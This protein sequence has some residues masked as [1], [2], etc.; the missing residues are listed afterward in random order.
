M[1]IAVALLTLAAGSVIQGIYE[2]PGG[3]FFIAIVV[4]VLILVG[5]LL[6]W[7][8]YDDVL[9]VVLVILGWIFLA[10]VAGLFLM[11]E[12]ILGFAGLVV[13]FL[14]MEAGQPLVSNVLSWWDTPERRFEQQMDTACYSAFGHYEFRPSDGYCHRFDDDEDRPKIIVP[15]DPDHSERTAKGALENIQRLKEQAAHSGEGMSWVWWF[16]VPAV[17][18]WGIRKLLKPSNEPSPTDPELERQ[19]A[20]EM[21]RWRRPG[22][23]DP[24]QGEIERRTRDYMSGRTTRF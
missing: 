4:I 20:R 2:A 23:D 19:I 10:A 5:G 13:L 12:P 18:V 11:G 15:P 8:Y 9:R 7:S 21:A 6:D 16:G 1:L 3:A 24:R 14:I 22:F 17:G